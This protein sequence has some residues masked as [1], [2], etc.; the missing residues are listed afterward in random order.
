MMKKL[1][2][3][4]VKYKAPVLYVFFGGVTT[5]VNIG[6]YWLCYDISGLS[7]DLSNIIS[8]FFSVLIAYITNKIWVFESKDLRF[9]FLL[10]EIVSF[11]ACRIATGV[12]DLGIMHLAVDMLHYPGVIFKVISNVIVIILNYIASKLL[13]FRKGIGK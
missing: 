5:V 13:I 8:W 2:E 12:I 6:V 10:L 7:N 1:F 3:L 11:F 9:K 4:F